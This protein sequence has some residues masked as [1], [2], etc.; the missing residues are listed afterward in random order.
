MGVTEIVVFGT[1]E[2]IDTVVLR[3]IAMIETVILGTKGI[4]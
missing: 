1:M 3:I 4:M 2:R